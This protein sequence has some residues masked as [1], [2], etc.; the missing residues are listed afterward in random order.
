MQ[1][2]K[3]QVLDILITAITEN[4][5]NEKLVNQLTAIKKLVSIF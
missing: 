3:H 4:K 5:D 1:I 2:I